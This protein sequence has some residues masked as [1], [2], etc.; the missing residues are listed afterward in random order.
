M[1]AFEVKAIKSSLFMKSKKQIVFSEVNDLIIGLKIQKRIMIE[2]SKRMRKLFPNS[3]H[4]ELS[5]AANITQDWIDNIAEE[6][7]QQE[8]ENVF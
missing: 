8:S 3:N 4:R 7:N 1:R 2:N 6:P 5:G